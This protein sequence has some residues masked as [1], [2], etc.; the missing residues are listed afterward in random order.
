MIQQDHSVALS[1]RVRATVALRKP[2]PDNVRDLDY[3]ADRYQTLYHSTAP[4]ALITPAVAHLSTLGELLRQSPAP[5]PVIAAP[6]SH[7]TD[8]RSGL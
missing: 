2:T 4:A 6:P 8:R 7:R 5:A 3:L 1:R